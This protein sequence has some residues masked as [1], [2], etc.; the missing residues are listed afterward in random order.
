MVEIIQNAKACS[1]ANPDCPEHPNK[2][3]SLLCMECKVGL[4]SKCFI[5]S[6]AKQHSDHQLLEIDDAFAEIKKTCDALMEKGKE[7]CQMLLSES[8]AIQDKR[9]KIESAAKTLQAACASKNLSV[10]DMKEKLSELLETSTSNKEHGT[11]LNPLCESRIA[12]RN[13]TPHTLQKAVDGLDHG[14]SIFEHTNVKYAGES[15]ALTK[16]A[17][18]TVLV[19]ALHMKLN[20][21][22]CDGVAE[23]LEYLWDLCYESEPCCR[24]M[25]LLG[26][27]DL[28]LSCFETSMT[29]E[30][31]CQK[32]LGVFST[33]VECCSLHNYLVIYQHSEH[34]NIL[35]SEF[36][37]GT[38]HNTS[39]RM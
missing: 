4:C 38:T 9:Y 6:A 2:A 19:E 22:V 21:G 14:K 11:V 32:V 5:S 30:E 16:L 8:Q 37:D 29:K 28:L 27:V 12:D 23:V 33:L 24:R 34:A 10:F 18:V 36:C 3:I 1:M 20:Q 13:C 39:P 7:T 31:I 35:H 25:V 15:V 26:G 17:S